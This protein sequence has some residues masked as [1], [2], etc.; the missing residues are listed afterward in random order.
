MTELESEFNSETDTF[1]TNE[2]LITFIKQDKGFYKN[3]F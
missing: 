2:N 1:I 3:S